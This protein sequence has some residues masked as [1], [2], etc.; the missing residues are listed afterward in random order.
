MDKKPTV[1]NNLT[2]ASQVKKAMIALFYPTRSDGILC[3][4]RNEWLEKGY[5]SVLEKYDVSI[6]LQ[7]HDELLF[8]APDT[9]SESA[10]TEIKEIM[11]NAITTKGFGCT[12]KSDT[13]IGKYWG[14][15][16]TFEELAQIARGEL[17]WRETFAKEVNKKMEK[18]LGYEYR[19]GIFAEKDEN[20]DMEQTD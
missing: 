15:N 7:V 6:L 11:Q 17:D 12:F 5:E 18:E 2:S 14:A 13:E 20:E 19:L 3:L 1:N 4:D 16:I 8:D 9:I 10:I